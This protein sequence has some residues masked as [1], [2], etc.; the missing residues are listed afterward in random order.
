M[1]LYERILEWL[2]EIGK[3]MDAVNGVTLP[4][5]HLS[6]DKSVAVFGK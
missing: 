1:R 4:F 2:L 5:R 6:D 3:Q